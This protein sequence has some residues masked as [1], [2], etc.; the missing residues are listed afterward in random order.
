ME[1]K[2]QSGCLNAYNSLSTLA[3]PLLWEDIGTAGDAR[4]LL[5][6]GASLKSEANSRGR[7]GAQEDKRKQG[8]DPAS[9][10]YG[11]AMTIH[12]VQAKLAE[13]RDAVFK[14]E[15]NGPLLSCHARSL[16]SQVTLPHVTFTLRI[17]CNGQAGGAVGVG[18]VCMTVTSCE[19]KMLQEAGLER[20]AMNGT[21]TGREFHDKRVLCNCLLLGWG[22]QN[23]KAFE[24]TAFIS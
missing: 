13:I 7:D 14:L 23:M 12:N 4:P 22:L 24:L 2:P 6:A 17:S 20:R 9:A 5:P 1:R 8:S 19:Q 11:L 3:R 16:M 15:P 21:L 18:R 10:F